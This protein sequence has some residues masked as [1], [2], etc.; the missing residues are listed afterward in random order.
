MADRTDR[1]DREA[2]Q[3]L[4]GARLHLG[5]FEQLED[6]VC[7]AAQEHVL[8]DVEVVAE[9]EILVHDLDAEPR[10]VLRAR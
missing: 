6:V 4:R 9:R 3:G 1:R 2:L 8:D 7:L 5:L 10:G